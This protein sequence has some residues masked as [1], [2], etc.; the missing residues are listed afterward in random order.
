MKVGCWS[1]VL[2]EQIYIFTCMSDYR[3]GFGFERLQIVT[4]SNYSAITYSHT[5]AHYN[6]C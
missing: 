1:T 5:S 4:T 6:T 2:E 3:G